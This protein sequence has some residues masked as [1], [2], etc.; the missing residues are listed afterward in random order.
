MSLLRKTFFYFL[1]TSFKSAWANPQLQ[2][3]VPTATP[4]SSGQASTP[5]VT[6]IISTIALG[7]FNLGGETISGLEEELTT[8]SILGISSGT[9]SNGESESET[10]YYREIVVSD[11]VE[12]TTTGGQ[13]I[14]NTLV[15]GQIFT[16]IGETLLCSYLALEDETIVENASGYRAFAS[17][18]FTIDGSTGIQNTYETCSFGSDGV[19]GGCSESDVLA[20]GAGGS[21]TTLYH[22]ISYQG[23]IA[24]TTLTLP[25]QAQAAVTSSPSPSSTASN[26]GNST[27]T[28]SGSGSA[29]NGGASFN[30]AGL[31]ML[32]STICLI[33]SSLLLVLPSMTV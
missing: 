19:S 32:T 17:S 18:T 1:L 21:S 24:G 7:G 10:T 25:F 33:L 16:D 23:S 5:V 6:A 9:G 14:P 31:G 20:M 8:I 29:K 2:S 4:S 27:S 28:G 11:A 15:P 22:T 12:T 30:G 3:S 13:L 26:S